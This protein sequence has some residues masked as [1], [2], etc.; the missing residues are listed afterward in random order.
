[1]PT[2]GYTQIEISKELKSECILPNSLSSIEKKLKAIRHFYKANSNFHL[3]V[4][5]NN[6]NVLKT[7]NPM[8]DFLIFKNIKSK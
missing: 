8:K 3:A 7:K 1:M 5:L 4:I 6:L 2:K